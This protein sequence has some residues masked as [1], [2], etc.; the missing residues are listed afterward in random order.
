MAILLLLSLSLTPPH[1]PSHSLNPNLQNPKHHPFPSSK[2]ISRRNL[3]SLALISLITLNPLPKSLADPSPPS[4]S[5][6]LAIE[7]TKSWFR[8]Y[9]D[10]FSIRV[11]PE[12]QDAQEPEDYATGFSYYGDKAKTRTYAARFASADGSEV[13]SVVIRPANQLKITFLQFFNKFRHLLPL[14]TGQATDITDLGSLKQAAKIF[15]PRR[16]NIYTARTIKIKDD[17]GFQTYY[18][19]EFGID[20]LHATLVASVNNGRAFIAGSNAPQSKWKDDGTKLRSA[21]MSL[22]LT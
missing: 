2:T 16:A 12:F 9:G 13:V 1:P 5:P 4:K 6:P 10:G 18:Y 11:P 8:F 17:E 21:A 19:Y 20:Q 7:N 22:T 14:L 15:V 3:T